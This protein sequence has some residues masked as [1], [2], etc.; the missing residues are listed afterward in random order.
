MAR[1]RP[2]LS[3]VIPTLNASEGLA[4]TLAALGPADEIIVVDG[5]S[6]DGTAALAR[7]IGARVIETARGRGG[8]LA[9]GAMAATS[10][11]ILFLHADTALSAGWREVVQRH[12]SRPDAEGQAACFRFALDDDSPQA[13]RLERWVTWR[14]AAL[15]L[16]YGDQGLLIH[17][18]LYD[19]V[20]GFRPLPLMEDVDLVRRLG[21]RRVTV[22]DAS[23][24]TSARRWRQDGWLRRSARNL[25]CLTL[26]YAGVPAERIARLYGR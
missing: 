26:F 3:V 24:I 16:P 4:A 19:R 9:A 2:R 10:D 14:V 12:L 21:R 11:W 5:G 7:D 6:R 23:A 22:L 20:G 1:E 8:Q 13:R 18:S 25:L 15:A 17:R